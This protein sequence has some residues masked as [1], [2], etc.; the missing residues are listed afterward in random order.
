VTEF[1][2][3]VGCGELP[4]DLALVGVGRFLPGGQFDVQHGEVVDAP[5]E[6]LPGQ[7]GQLDLGP[8]CQAGV[9]RPAVVGVG[10]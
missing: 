5:V 10:Y 7:A 4:V 1:D 3:G 9:R 2:A 8:L 6:A